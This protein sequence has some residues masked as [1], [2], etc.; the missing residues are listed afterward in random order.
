[1]VRVT[2]QFGYAVTNARVS[3]NNDAGGT[4]AYA[5]SVTDTDGS[6]QAVYTLGAGAGV[7]HATVMVSTAAGAMLATISV[8]SYRVVTAASHLAPGSPR[9]ASP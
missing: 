4:F 7:Q 5:S 2:D 8:T 6:A 1:V 9:D 3:W